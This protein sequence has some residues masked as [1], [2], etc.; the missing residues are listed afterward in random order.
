LVRS[1]NSLLDLFL[2]GFI[3]GYESYLELCGAGYK[4]KLIETIFGFGLVLRLGFSHLIFINLFK[5]FRI[6]FLNK[7]IISFYSSNL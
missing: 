5:H 3:R 6:Y 1:L 4:F 2:F 7:F